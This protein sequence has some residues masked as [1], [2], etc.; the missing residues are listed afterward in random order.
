M[1]RHP[2]R[3]APAR[4]LLLIVGWLLALTVQ[5]QSVPEYRLLLQLSDYSLDHFNAT[6][7]RALDA[8][9]VFGEG[10]VRIEIVALEDGVRLLR[11]EAPPA[12][13]DKL[14]QVVARG[15]RVLGCGVALDSHGLQERDLLESV[16]IIPSGLAHL[17]VR[18]QQGWAY[19]AP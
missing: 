13:A 2:R 7:N 8:G 9:H 15:V 19:L 16:V 12:L 3:F 17:V 5:A 4:G 10:Q 6:L 14:A 18:Q 11:R 1:P